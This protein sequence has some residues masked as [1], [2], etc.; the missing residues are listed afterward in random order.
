MPRSHYDGVESAI[1]YCESGS[2]SSRCG[3][4]N[5]SVYLGVAAVELRSAIGC[6]ESG[7]ASRRCGERNRSVYASESLRYRCE[8]GLLRYQYTPRSRYDG[9]EMRNRLPR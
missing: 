4:R 9:V 2:A 1:G 8:I 6:C 3:E 5:R 7:S